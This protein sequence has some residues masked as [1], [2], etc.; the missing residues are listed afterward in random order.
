[1]IVA[2]NVRGLNASEKQ[3]DVALFV[4]SNRIGILGPLVRGQVVN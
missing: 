2:W 3:C 4:K 1:M